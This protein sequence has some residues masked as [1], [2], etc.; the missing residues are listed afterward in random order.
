VV[1]ILCLTKA[2]AGV[3]RTV[4]GVRVVR[5]ADLANEISGR[6]R[7]LELD[8]AQK[9]AAALGRVLPTVTGPRP[10]TEDE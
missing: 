4:S 6:P 7:V 5:L 3:S 2:T 8:S 9:A 1:P 10:K